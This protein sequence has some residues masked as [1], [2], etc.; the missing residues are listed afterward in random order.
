MKLH[1]QCPWYL[2][3]LR[4]KSAEALP[5]FAKATWGI[6]NVAFIHGFTPVVFR[7]GG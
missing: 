2:Q 7:E 6:R 4:A 5:H 1:G 3:M